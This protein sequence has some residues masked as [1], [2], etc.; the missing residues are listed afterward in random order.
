[1][2]TCLYFAYGSNM[3]TARLQHR[4]ETALSVTV[5]R[6]PNYRLAFSKRAMDGSGKATLVPGEAGSE[7]FGVVFEIAARELSVLDAFE[8]PAYRR[9]D[10][11]VTCIRTGDEISAC[12]YLARERHDDLKP[13]DWYL[14]LILAGIEEHGIGDDYASAIR[15]AEYEVDEQT[16]RDAR[17]QALAAFERANLADYARLLTPAASSPA[18][19]CTRAF[20]GTI[21]QRR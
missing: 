9:C 11:R 6:A 12:T 8:G 19:P 10:F 15:A 20:E 13:H 2:T 21:L 1:M 16:S 4:C 3:L 5:A 14:A 17:L 18:A 7:V